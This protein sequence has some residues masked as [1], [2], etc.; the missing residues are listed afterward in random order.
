MQKAPKGLFENDIFAKLYEVLSA[1]KLEEY[2]EEELTMLRGAAR[3]IIER[4]EQRKTRPRR[5][6]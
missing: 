2:P 5:R 6:R 3:L 1:E 4:V